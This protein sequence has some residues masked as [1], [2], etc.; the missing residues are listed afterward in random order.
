M[1]ATP[2]RHE[3][4]FL[5]ELPSLSVLRI[6]FQDGKVFRLRTFI[7]IDSSVYDRPDGWNAVIVECMAPID[8]WSQRLFHPGGGIDFYES[9]VATIVDEKTGDVLYSSPDPEDPGAAD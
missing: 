2:N 8:P 6:S 4:L 9:D 3:C 1:T 5:A 7:Q